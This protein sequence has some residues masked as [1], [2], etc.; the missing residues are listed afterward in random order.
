ME[1]QHMLSSDIYHESNEQFSQ[2][3]QKDEGILL[4]YARHFYL[5]VAMLVGMNFAV[6][7]YTFSF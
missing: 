4:H 2:S 5:V 3:I 1:A 7:A 6:K